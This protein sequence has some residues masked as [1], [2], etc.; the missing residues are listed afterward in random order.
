ML[1]KNKHI[2]IAEDNSQN[3]IIFQM[4]LVRQ[5]AKI[6]FERWGDDAIFRLHTMPQ[7]DLIILDLSLAA[8][9]SGYDIFKQIRA[10]P[11]F[12]GV[13]I[14]AVSATDPSQGI[15]KTREMG[16]AGFIAKPI[17]DALFPKQLL[18]IINGEHIWYAGDRT[19]S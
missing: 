6:Y 1:L 17:D 4:M 13:P 14:V 10:A 19:L 12:D 11:E 18:S 15:P 5:G 7:C 9:I 16:F 8:G 2:F 3:R